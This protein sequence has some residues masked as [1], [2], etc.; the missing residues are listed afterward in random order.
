MIKEEGSG[1]RMARTQAPAPPLTSRGT[2]V[3]QLL[4]RCRCSFLSGRRW[5]S[6]ENGAMRVKCLT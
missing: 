6:R 1:V 3:R 5:G 4:L 2:R